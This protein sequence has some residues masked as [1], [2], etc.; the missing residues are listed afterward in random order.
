MSSSENLAKT[1]LY[2]WHAAHGG[3]MVD[4]AGWAMPVQYGSIVGEHHATRNAVGLFDISH[5]GR[6]LFSGADAEAFLD[7]LSTRKVTDLKPGQIRYSL[8]CNER[9]GVL[10]DVLIYRI[11]LEDGVRSGSGRLSG[12]GMVVNASNRLK[13]VDWINSHLVGQDVQV[14]DISTEYAMIALQGPK[15]IE[16]L[17]PL[18]H[19]PLTSLRYYTGAETKVDGCGC[20]L[21]RTGYTGEDGCEIVVHADLAAQLWESLH[22]KAAEADGMAV[23]LAARN[24]LRLEAGMPLYGHELSEDIN[25]IQA[26]LGFAVTLKDRQFIGRDALVAATQDKGQR[27]RVGLQLDGR[28]APREGY[29]VLQENEV[30]GEV[31]S[32]TFSPTLDRPIAMAYVKPTAAAPGEPVAVDFRGSQLPATIAPPVFYERGK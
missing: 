28:R 27:V 21:S 9:G 8:I 15:A 11:E 7:S 18:T 4:Y 23:G 3:R 25:P 26:G 13:I 19:H 6:L 5:M 22:A 10:D 16:L 2:D 24:T 32:G 30:V 12:F 14:E 1:P 29:P 20:Y 31:T 17:E